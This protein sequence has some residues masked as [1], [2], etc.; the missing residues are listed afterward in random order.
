MNDAPN[1]EIGFYHLEK[2]PLETAVPRLLG[3]ALERGL[4]VVVRTGSEER[5]DALNAALWSHDPGSFLPHGGPGDGDA[6]RQPVYLTTG[7]E[8]PNGATVLVLTDR[9]EAT[10]LDRFERCIDMFDGSDDSVQAARA[11]WRALK[12]KDYALTYWQQTPAGK[13]EKKP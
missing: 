2:W 12:D 1:T 10:D 6:D 3:R 4:R 8:V 5:L 9:V 11:R 7:D 13:W